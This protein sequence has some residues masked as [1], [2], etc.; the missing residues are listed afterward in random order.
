MDFRPSTDR[1][2]RPRGAEEGSTRLPTFE[3]VG[4]DFDGPAWHRPSGATGRRDI[5]LSAPRLIDL[6]RRA[7]FAQLPLDP[8]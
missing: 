2:G 8:R 6:E 4:H 1:A 7:R 5:F 3:D